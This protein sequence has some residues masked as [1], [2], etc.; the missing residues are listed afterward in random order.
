[1]CEDITKSYLI[2]LY[3]QVDIVNTIV[4]AKKP[5]NNQ[6][7]LKPI[8]TAAADIKA[9]KGKDPRFNNH[10]QAVAD[11]IN[12][13]AWFI[14]PDLKEY[15]D[16]N[17]PAI[18]FYG[19]K[20]LMLKQEPHTKWFK[21][22]KAIVQ[23]LGKWVRMNKVELGQWKGSEDAAKVWG[24]QN[25]KAWAAKNGG[26]VS[27]QTATTATAAPANPAPKA[28]PATKPAEKKKEPKKYC[29][30]N[31]WYIENY[32]KETITLEGEENV[33]TS[34]CVQMLNCRE[35]TV[36]IKGKL[37]NIMLNKTFK[38]KMQCETVIAC[39]EVLNSEKTTIYAKGTIP[40]VM[41]ENTNSLNFYAFPDA[42]RAK[43]NTTCCQSVVV[44]FPKE[45]ATDDDEWLDFPIAETFLTVIKGDMLNTEP[46]EGMDA[47]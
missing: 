14:A 11:G 1:M 32:G 42:K 20:V 34:H 4:G 23:A 18:D 8:Q 25:G 27:A 6:L 44:H 10:V 31:T 38:C 24:V 46:L 5:D 9:H 12:V 3:A 43:F 29:E 28:S 19:N 45:N 37:K 36:I 21:A 26:S 22:F 35:T 40:Q 39:L 13:L 30:N 41:L 47:V 2:A 33:S 16:E 17:V 7:F 15:L